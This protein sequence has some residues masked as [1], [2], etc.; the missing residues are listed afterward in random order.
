[1]RSSSDEIGRTVASRRFDLESRS[2]SSDTALDTTV[3]SSFARPATTDIARLAEPMQCATALSRST[4]VSLRI[5]RIAAGW[6]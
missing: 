3:C 6:S 4:P 1:M 2:T 5:V